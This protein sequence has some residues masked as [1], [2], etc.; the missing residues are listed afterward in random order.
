MKFMHVNYKLNLK[1]VI[2]KQ[3]KGIVFAAWFWYFCRYQEIV[4]CRSNLLSLFL[5]RDA[6]IAQELQNQL[7]QEDGAN[8][9]VPPSALQTV[10]SNP[11]IPPAPGQV[12]G[13]S[14]VNLSAGSAVCFNTSNRLYFSDISS[15]TA[16]YMLV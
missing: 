15:L 11:T 9:P 6:R 14:T 4:H 8:I 3:M 10:A 7:N 5:H 13:S 1:L 16:I 12:S 2:V